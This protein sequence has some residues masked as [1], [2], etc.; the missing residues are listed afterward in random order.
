MIERAGHKE[1]NERAGADKGVFSERPTASLQ[2]RKK[3]AD[4]SVSISI[5]ES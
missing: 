3:T 4:E 5:R 2:V 1:S